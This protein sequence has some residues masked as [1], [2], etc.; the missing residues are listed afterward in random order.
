V[1]QNHLPRPLLSSIIYAAFVDADFWTIFGTFGT[2]EDNSN[3]NPH[4]FCSLSAA[5]PHVLFDLVV[6]VT[7]VAP[8]RVTHPVLV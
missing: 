8:P 7:H 2:T 4:P 1:V 5:E 6:E 3:P